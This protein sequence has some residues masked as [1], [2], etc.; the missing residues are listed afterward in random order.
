MKLSKYRKYQAPRVREAGLETEGIF[1]QSFRGLME[2][3]PA[4]N[5]NT[6]FDDEGNTTEPLNIEF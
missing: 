1:C 5:R 2:V 4:D 3:D 6:Y